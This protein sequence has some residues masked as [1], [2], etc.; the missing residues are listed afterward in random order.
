MELSRG[1]VTRFNP[2]KGW[3]FIRPDDGGEDVMLHI[4]ALR[5]PADASRIRPGTRV[6][7][8]VFRS[9]RGLRAAQVRLE[10]EGK[11]RVP[12]PGAAA[13]FRDE[14]AGVLGAAVSAIEDIARKHGWVE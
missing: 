3:G 14:V 6:S 11:L 12:R 1:K 8:T 7:C 10:P 9:D 13:A 5:D 4:Q 2:D